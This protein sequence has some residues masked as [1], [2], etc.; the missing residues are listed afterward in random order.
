MGNRSVYTKGP[1]FC[2]H[3]ALWCLGP[4][5]FQA[6]IATILIL[7]GTYDLIV[8]ASL[9]CLTQCGQV[10]EYITIKYIIPNRIHMIIHRGL[11][12]LAVLWVATYTPGMVNLQIATFLCNGYPFNHYTNFCFVITVFC[13][14]CFLHQVLQQISLSY[15]PVIVHSTCQNLLSCCVHV[16]ISKKIRCCICSNGYHMICI[17]LCPDYIQKFTEEMNN[18]HCPTCL[19]CLFPYNLISDENDFISAIRYISGEGT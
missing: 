7:L 13:L 1:E 6:T 8:V 18:W 10:T 17:T 16:L 9:V 12:E 4:V 5:R 11:N 3:F 19:S 14:W 15:S 2:L